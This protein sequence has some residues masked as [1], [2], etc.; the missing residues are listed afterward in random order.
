MQLSAQ[1]LPKGLPGSTALEFVPGIA[2]TDTVQSATY[3]FEVPITR[4]EAYSRI[5][6]SFSS[7]PG[8][9]LIDGWRRGGAPGSSDYD[10]PMWA[11]NRLTQGKAG[12]VGQLGTPS[13]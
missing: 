11:A 10:Q 9:D 2:G 6:A 5:L 3:T 8:S 4:E 7:S 13:S 1:V 12:S